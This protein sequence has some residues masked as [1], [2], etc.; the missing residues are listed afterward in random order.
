M[1]IARILRDK[2]C[3]GV[4][5]DIRNVVTKQRLR[6]SGSFDYSLDAKMTRVSDNQT[7]YDGKALRV[8]F[9][10]CNAGLLAAA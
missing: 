1:V 5:A 6:P 7:I 3:Y 10:D 4:A 9:F 2:A 8:G